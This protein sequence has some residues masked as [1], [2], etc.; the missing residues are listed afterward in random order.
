MAE[1]LKSKAT[2]MC[3]VLFKAGDTNKD[4]VLQPNEFKAIAMAVCEKTNTPWDMTDEKFDALFKNVDTDG[5]GALDIDEYKKIAMPLCQG[6]LT[7]PNGD[8]VWQFIV[9]SQK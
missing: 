1:E 8:K 9:A 4:G 5:S 3:E 6:L 7:G 2:I